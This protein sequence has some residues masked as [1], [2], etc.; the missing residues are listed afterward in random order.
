M[1]SSCLLR[2]VLPLP[3]NRSRSVSTR[4][5]SGRRCHVMFSCSL[6]VI[7]FVNRHKSRLSGRR[8]DWSQET[9]LR[10]L[11]EYCERSLPNGFDWTHG[12][13]SGGRTLCTE[14]HDTPL[15]VVETSIREKQVYAFVMLRD[16]NPQK[17]RKRESS[18]GLGSGNLPSPLDLLISIR[19]EELLCFL[20][21]LVFHASFFL[22][23]EFHRRHR[24]L[25]P[26]IH[27]N[28]FPGTQADGSCSRS[29]GL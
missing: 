7:E 26:L 4:W 17:E 8:S 28:G 14:S 29:G 18:F 22:L 24:P 16:E 9:R 21:H 10:Y 12:P 5:W 27:V 25:L 11:G 23:T 1:P 6:T 3:F 20:S 15:S 2:A 19:K 13:Y